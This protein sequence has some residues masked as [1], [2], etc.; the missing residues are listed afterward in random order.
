MNLRTQVALGAGRFTRW[1]LKTFTKGGSSMP[2]KVAHA[3][4]PNILK[5]L[6]ENYDVI[7]V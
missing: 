7:I 6:A 2:G 4:D 5:S 1:A 3:I